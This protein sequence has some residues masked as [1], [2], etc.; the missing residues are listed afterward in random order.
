M[1]YAFVMKP[2]QF[3]LLLILTSGV[4]DTIVGQPVESYLADRSK[5]SVFIS[6]LRSGKAASLFEGESDARIWLRLHNNTRIPIYLCHHKVPKAYGDAGF[7]RSVFES[8]QIGDRRLEKLGYGSTDVCDVFEIQ[9]AGSA[10]FS[11]PAEE[12]T[13]KKRLIELRFHFGWNKDWKRDL[14]ENSE[15]IIRYGGDQLPTS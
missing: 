10:V 3:V 9:S 12:L 14:Y 15:T 7:P 1:P 11:V 8:L 4:V 5:P 6:Y 13:P 2:F